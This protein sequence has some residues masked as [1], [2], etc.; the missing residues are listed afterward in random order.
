[1]I[2]VMGTSGGVGG[3]SPGMVLRKIANRHIAQHYPTTVEVGPEARSNAMIPLVY[4]S[5]GYGDHGIVSEV[6]SIAIDS[7]TGSV[8]EVTARDEVVAL[9]RNLHEENREDIEAAF[10]SVA[11][12]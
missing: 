6:G 9:V 5:P 2:A 3:A 8:V 11:A 10:H 1:M 4:A 12:K 7:R